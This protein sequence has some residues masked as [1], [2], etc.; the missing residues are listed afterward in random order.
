MGCLFVFSSPLFVQFR[1]LRVTFKVNPSPGMAAMSL[2]LDQIEVEALG[3]PPEE[4]ARLAERLLASLGEERAVI[5]RSWEEEIRRR[6]ADFDAGRTQAIPASE[7]FARA[8]ARLA[9]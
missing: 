2:T 7:V 4:R 1:G 5:E 6:L 3:L 9:R 8:R